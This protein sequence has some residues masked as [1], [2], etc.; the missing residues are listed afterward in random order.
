M[1]EIPLSDELVER[2]TRAGARLRKMQ[3]RMRSVD[4]RN[5][6][7]HA[8]G[9]SYLFTQRVRA[10]NV[11]RNFKEP[12]IILKRTHG[13]TNAKDTVSEIGRMVDEHNSRPPSGRYE[14][15]RPH[16]YA[17]AVDLIAMAK[18]LK[19]TVADILSDTR[20]GVAYFTRLKQNSPITKDALAAAFSELHR[21]TRIKGEHVLLVGYS[22]GKFLFMPLLD[23]D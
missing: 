14:F 11:R 22:R 4:P 20:K 7:A 15:L 3:V 1:P 19:P 16:A 18:T 8:E 17:V 21:R 5:P 10:M 6:L 9:S 23:L 12:E 13:D 2:L